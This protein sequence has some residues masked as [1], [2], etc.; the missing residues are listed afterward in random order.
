[1]NGTGMTASAMAKAG[2][3]A[4]RQNPRLAAVEIAW[5]WVFGALGLLWFALGARSM[6]LATKLTPEDIAAIRGG[7]AQRMILAVLHIGSQPGFWS[8]FY[9]TMAAVAIPALILWII[10][11]TIGRLATLRLMGLTK[12]RQDTV[13]GL[14]TMRAAAMVAAT[15]LWFGWMVVSASLSLSGEAGP[16][17]LMYLALSMLALPVILLVWGLVNWLLSLAPVVADD[18]VKASLRVA[19]SGCKARRKDISAVSSYFATA[20]L[21]GMMLMILLMIVAAFL[22]AVVAGVFVTL[23]GLAY[24]GFA[25]YLYVA[26]LAGY[27]LM[28]RGSS[29]R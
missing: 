12:V 8:R 1:M 7:D 27:A 23:I 10:C 2:M 17:Y 20:R 16:N 4:V 26:R 5:R 14:M 29:Q 22:P 21:V 9:L 11:G 19:S 15:G 3:Q 6:L 25:D 24:C 13:L 18:G 28:L